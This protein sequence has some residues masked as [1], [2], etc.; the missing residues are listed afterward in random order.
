PAAQSPAGPPAG[1]R[2]GVVGDFLFGLGEAATYVTGKAAGFDRVQRVGQAVLASSGAVRVTEEGG[3]LHCLLADLVA[4]DPRNPDPSGWRG[5]FASVRMDV[6]A[7]SVDVAVDQFATLPLYYLA[8]GGSLLLA[9]DLRHLLDCPWVRREADP[10]AIYHLLNFGFIPAPHA[11]VGDIRRMLPA[12]R[13]AF[14]AGRIDT[15]RYWRPPYAED[16]DGD[17]RGLA[18]RLRERIVATVERYRP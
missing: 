5:R 6:A 2:T 18:D 1:A 3:S 8:R 10:L 9:T 11:I 7:S 15:R 12:T 16:L 4:G 14:A 17:E 13:L